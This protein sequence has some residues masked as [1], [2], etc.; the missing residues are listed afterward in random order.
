M[1][2]GHLRDKFI[3]AATYGDPGV[4]FL[5]WNAEPKWWPP[6][7]KSSILPAKDVLG[8]ETKFCL[9]LKDFEPVYFYLR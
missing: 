5:R 2:A 1:H 8:F 3:R 6:D 7:N 4:C 9:P